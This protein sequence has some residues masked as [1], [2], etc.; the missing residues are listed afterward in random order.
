MTNTYMC[1]RTPI[2]AHTTPEDIMGFMKGP[3]NMMAYRCR[4]CGDIIIRS[5]DTGFERLHKGGPN[6]IEWVTVFIPA[7][8]V[9]D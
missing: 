2:G 5:N 8:G 3:D 7:E 9:E 6:L 1:P 4:A